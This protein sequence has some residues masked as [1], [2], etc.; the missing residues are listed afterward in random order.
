MKIWI[1]I[2]RTFTKNLRNKVI[3]SQADQSI[4]ILSIEKLAN[5]KD[6]DSD[7]DDNDLMNELG[8]LVSYLFV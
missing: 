3:I 5:A 4:S 8:D 2:W 7:I 1:L 6:G